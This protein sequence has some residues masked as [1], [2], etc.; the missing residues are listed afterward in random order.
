MGEKIKRSASSTVKRIDERT[1]E[2]LFEMA[3]TPRHMQTC[4]VN[5]EIVD[6]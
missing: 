1:E 5:R 3:A 2:L 4:Y 6:T